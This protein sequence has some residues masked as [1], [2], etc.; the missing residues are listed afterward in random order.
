MLEIANKLVKHFEQTSGVMH[1]H[2]ADALRDA[3]TLRDWI[4]AQQNEQCKKC[5]EVYPTVKDKNGIDI[6]PSC[7]TPRPV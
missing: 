2:S 5:L 4:A 7:G 6:C 1:S 3:K